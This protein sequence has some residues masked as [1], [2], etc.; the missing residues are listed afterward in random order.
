MLQTVSV[1]KDV[2]LHW[3][4]QP[5]VTDGC[6]EFYETREAAFEAYKAAD[7][8]WLRP[9]GASIGAGGIVHLR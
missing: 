5:G 8:H 7:I 2:D 6:L 3:S 9:R 4:S 1:D